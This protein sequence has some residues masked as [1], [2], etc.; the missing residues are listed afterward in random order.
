MIRPMC[1]A[2]A[3]LALPATAAA[4]GLTPAQVAKGFTEGVVLC[5]KA[6]V[7]RGSVGDLPAEDQALITVADAAERSFENVPEG[8]PAWSVR[9]GAGIVSVSEPTVGTCRVSAYGPRVVPTFATVA[10]ALAAEGF[11]EEPEAQT[12]EA[13]TRKFVR[14]VDGRRVVV[15]LDGGEPGMPGRMFRFPLLIADVG[16]LP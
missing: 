16:V 2:L 3:L 11:V 12:P 9:A 14:V 13:I 15:H 8:R 5:A 4:Q 10:A 1:A 6:G 7:L